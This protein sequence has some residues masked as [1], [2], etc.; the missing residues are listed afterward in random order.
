MS[1]TPVVLKFF[2][3]TKFRDHRPP[4]FALNIEKLK[5]KA[6]RLELKGQMD[7]AI[8][9]YAKIL[10]GLDGTPELSDELALFNKLGDLYLKRGDRQ[11]AVEEWQRSIELNPNQPELRS[12]LG[13]LGG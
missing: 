7:K 5:D 2:R 1:A 13:E 8:E 4:R 6:R 10:E 11:S 12:M 9:Q 3:L